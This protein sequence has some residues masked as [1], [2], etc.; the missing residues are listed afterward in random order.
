M[1]KLPARKLY[2]SDDGIIAGVSVGLARYFKLP[3]LL[4]RILFLLLLVVG[5]G[6]PLYILFWILAPRS[7][8]D[9]ISYRSGLSMPLIFLLGIVVA[10]GIGFSFALEISFGGALLFLVGFVVGLVNLMKGRRIGDTD[11]GVSE[12]EPEP[13]MLEGIGTVYTIRIGVEKKIAGV[14]AWLSEKSGI[15]VTIIRVIAIILAFFTFPIVPIL[16]LVAAFVLPKQEK[17]RI[18]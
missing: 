17:L 4:I 3:P 2:R 15:D 7:R 9:G 1:S 10:I 8:A 13:E 12:A 6:L 11:D 16:Y 14:C 18:H 5:P